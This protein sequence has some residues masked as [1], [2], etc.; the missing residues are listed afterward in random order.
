M[1]GRTAVTAELTVVAISE[2]VEY[3]ATTDEED[4]AAFSTFRLMMHAFDDGLVE[5]RKVTALVGTPRATATGA[6]IAADVAEVNDAHPVVPD[7]VAVKLTAMTSTRGA[8]QAAT[9]VEPAGAVWP[10]GHGIHPLL[11]VDERYVFTAQARDT[12]AADDVDSAGDVVPDGHD[13]QVP[14]AP[15]N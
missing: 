13:S 6:V 9:D 14:A 1:E 3:R 8:T 15:T 12:Q 2:V 4:A 7:G 5:D 11:A 10:A